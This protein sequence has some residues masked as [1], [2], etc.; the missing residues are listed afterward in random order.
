MKTP[1]IISIVGLSGS[2]KTTLTE[3]VI[4]ILA[5]KKYKVASIKHSCHPHPLDAK[6]KDSWRHKN[7]GAIRTVFA[8]PKAMQLITDVKGEK[9]PKEIAKEFFLGMDVVIVEGFLHSKTDKIEVVRKERSEEPVLTP[10]KGLVAIVTDIKGLA[11]FKNT[12]V[13]DLNDAKS[14][15]AFIITR[16]KLK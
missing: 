12:P 11:P 9:T 7:A 6:G 2:G 10:K 14:V 15:A 4:A 1:P 5:K 8:G 3:K 13:F 16:L